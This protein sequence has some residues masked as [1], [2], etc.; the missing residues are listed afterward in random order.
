M[1]IG[2]NNTTIA[3]T[4]DDAVHDQSPE[5]GGRAR[6]PARDRAAHGADQDRI[7]QILWVR[8]WKNGSF[9][10]SSLVRESRKSL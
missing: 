6:E 2:I 1:E 8:I 9:L 4:A 3:F 7:Q 5:P 10:V